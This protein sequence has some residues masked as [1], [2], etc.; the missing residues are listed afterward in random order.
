VTNGFRLRPQSG[1]SVSFVT[2][3]DRKVSALTR[4]S[5]SSSDLVGDTQRLGSTRWSSAVQMAEGAISNNLFADILGIHPVA[6]SVGPIN[7]V[8]GSKRDAFKS[9]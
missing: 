3:R 7:R 5:Y 6:A 2:P 8:E 9:H 4:R 1:T